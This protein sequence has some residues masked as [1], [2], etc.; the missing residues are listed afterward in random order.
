VF[1]VQEELARAVVSALRGHLTEGDSAALSR[2]S[3][4]NVESYTLY[5]K[6]RYHWYRRTPEGLRQ[7]LS[8]FEQ[9]VA[10]DPTYA[11]AYAGIGDVY[12]LLGS[13]DYGVLP[14]ETAFPAAKR[15]LKRALELD[16]ESAGAHAALGNV[17]FTFDW[18]WGAA[19]VEFERALELDPG[20]TPALHWYALGLLAR[21]KSEE[22]MAAMRRAR[23]LEPL[24]MVL[25]TAMARLLHLDGLTDQAIGEYRR[26]LELDPSF[27]TAHLGLGLSYVHSGAPD[28]AIE[29]YQAA[30]R[31]LGGE[32]PLVLALIAHAGAL[33]GRGEMARA[34]L[35]RLQSDALR[36]YVPAEYLGLVHLGLGERSLALDALDQAFA[37]R[38]GS[39]AFLRLDPL[40]DPLRG[41]PRFE[42]LLQNVP[43]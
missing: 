26:I 34:A 8:Y 17:H 4:P 20:C 2:T 28:L 29:E 19:E 43:L 14:P 27:V 33:A 16:P 30:N 9:S 37:N 22:A 24:S 31:L 23:E 6:G 15:A 38:S 25:N 32:Q 39:M 11:L 3:T 12:S 41:E 42:A 21:G 5:L 35:G 1:A 18:A 10:R 36:S 7:A 40:F 13:H